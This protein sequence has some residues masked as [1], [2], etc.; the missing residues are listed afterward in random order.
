MNSLFKGFM[1][2]DLFISHKSFYKE[3]ELKYNIV[4]IVL[5][6]KN[7]HNICIKVDGNIFTHTHIY[8]YEKMIA[9]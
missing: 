9:P 7:I 2:Y 3:K 1:V 8:I 6:R 5:K 4:L